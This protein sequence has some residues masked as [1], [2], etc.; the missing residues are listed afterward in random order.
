MRQWV[1]QDAFGLEHLALQE[2]ADPPPPG[3]GEARVRMRAW[4]LNYRDLLMARGQYDPRLQLPYVPLSDG[5]GVVEAVGVGVE[6]VAVGDRVCPTFCP[7]WLAGAP[8][9]DAVRRTRGGPVPGVLA[10]VVQL[11]AAELVRV[12]AR[13][14]DAEAASLP[15]AAVTAWNALVTVGR[16]QPGQTALVIGSG[17]VSSAAVAIARS[18]GARVV[19]VGRSPHK[20]ATLKGWG[21]E[22]WISSV[23]EPRWG[24]AARQ[25]SGGGVDVVVEVGGAGT[26]QQS[27]DAV[28]VAGTVAVIGNLA[29]AKE[30][31]S[32]LPVLMKAVRCHGVYVGHRRSFEALCAALAAGTRPPAI[33]EAYAF[34]DAPAAF[35]T[36]ASGEHAG[37]LCLTAAT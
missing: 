8:D 2:V 9:A 10:E 25:W 32:V 19:A 18:C 30:P 14:T 4:S 23:D 31:L 26:L 17:G 13:L 29:G 6:R 16:L 12:P 20:V 35:A 11:D 7:T 1:V 37:K 34:E 28:R 27:L 21:V 15:C 33:G 22:H 3:P 24:R 36:L 5:V